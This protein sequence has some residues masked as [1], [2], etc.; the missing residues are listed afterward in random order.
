MKDL[1]IEGNNISSEKDKYVK[2]SIQVYEMEVE[3]GIMVTASGDAAVSRY[4][5]GGTIE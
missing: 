1:S 2:P 3:T 5:D 4:D